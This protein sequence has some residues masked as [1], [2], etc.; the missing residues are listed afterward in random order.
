MKPEE[1][2]AYD[3]TQRQQDQQNPAV[4]TPNQMLGNTPQSVGVEPGGFDQTIGQ[5]SVG[6]SPATATSTP[7]SAPNETP[8]VSASS[9][10][11][12]PPSDTPASSGFFMAPPPQQMPTTTPTPMNMA[13]AD[14][15]TA[16]YPP[17]V[18]GSRGKRPWVI[19]GVVA[20]TVLLIA[21]GVGFGYYLPSTPGRVWSSGLG[22]SGKAL[23][24]VTNK[25]AEP[26]TIQQFQHSKMSLKANVTW[27][28]M[29]ANLAWSGNSDDKNAKGNLVFSS[30]DSSIPTEK[31]HGRLDYLLQYAGTKQ[32]PDVYFKV[33]DLQNLS[34]ADY[35]ARLAGYVNT[36]IFVSADALKQYYPGF[37]TEGAATNARSVTSQ[38]VADAA[39]A[40]TT[41]VQEYVLTGNPDKAVII[42][43]EF[44]GKEKIDDVGTYHY[45]AAIHKENAKKYCEALMPKMA[46]TQ[47]YKK[48]AAETAQ[49]DDEIKAA[50][51]SCQQS[52]E[53]SIKDTDVFDVWI[54][55]KYRLIHK[56]RIPSADSK[57]G[58]YT[59]F[60][61]NYKGGDTVSLFARFHQGGENAYD[62]EWTVDTNMPTGV[63]T[64][65]LTGKPQKVNENLLKFDVTFLSEPTQ[66]KVDGTAPKDAVP[67]T[68]ILNALGATP[69]G[70]NSSSPGNS[71]PI[72]ERAKDAERQTDINAINSHLEAFYAQNGSYPTL[73]DLQDNAFVAKNFSD[74]DTSA[75]L[76]PNQVS[77]TIQV[78]SSQ[79][80]AHYGYTALSNSGENC[81]NTVRTKMEATVTYYNSGCDDFILTATLSTGAAYTKKSTF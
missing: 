79:N 51:R 29:Q 3:F 33:S 80:P 42:Q 64:S 19:G 78:T 68:T 58:S 56:I 59:D 62:G 65:K 34:L 76:D 66:E 17:T 49:K 67:I 6:T 1:P 57:D 55:S 54:D 39:K 40:L 74:L 50:V 71:S 20:A 26:K 5:V 53:S 16:M 48:L 30:T 60:G 45:K 47:L 36:W 52:V 75:L 24:M 18:D 61:Q 15:G 70:T 35:D 43:K 73:A 4:Y 32:L 11:S 77:G 72:S 46:A 81:E 13:G 23:A 37:S 25:A 63:T 2:A 41:T 14:N 22:R 8:P 12:M 27:G 9:T 44:V 38:D 21:A 28:S 69:S 7:D 10:W 31:Y